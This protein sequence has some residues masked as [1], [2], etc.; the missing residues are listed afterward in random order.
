MSFFG[1][2]VNPALQDQRARLAMIGAR[3][4]SLEPVARFVEEGR[5]KNPDPALV[6]RTLHVLAEVRSLHRSMVDHFA[7]AT[8]P[9][10]GFDKSEQVQQAAIDEQLGLLNYLSVLAEGAERARSLGNPAPTVR[11]SFGAF[12]DLL[13]SRADQMDLEIAD[14]RLLKSELA[15]LWSQKLDLAQMSAGVAEVRTILAA[16]RKALCE[17]VTLGVNAAERMHTLEKTFSDSFETIREERA[18]V[19]ME[20]VGRDVIARGLDG[21]GE[22]P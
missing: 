9:H 4:E 13:S 17:G 12:L 1:R 10:I 22:M 11:D 3:L 7:T 2:K 14:L 6:E 21:S 8:A 18:L 15:G 16:Y 19:A 5:D 20:Q